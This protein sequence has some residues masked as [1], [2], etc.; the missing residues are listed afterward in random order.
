[1]LQQCTIHGE[2]EFMLPPPPW[3]VV[4]A[5][6]C[7]RRGAVVTDDTTNGVQLAADI[8]SEEEEEEEE[9]E[10]ESDDSEAERDADQLLIGANGGGG[11]SDGEGAGMEDGS[12]AESEESDIGAFKGAGK[13][14]KEG[15]SRKGTSGKKD[16]VGRENAVGVMWVTCASLMYENR[17]LLSLGFITLLLG[18]RAA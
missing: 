2:V 17:K 9:E 6:R 12:D 5:V 8:A 14:A 10:N 18:I 3:F 16:K 15:K 4:Y 1:M 7:I 11:D 13:R